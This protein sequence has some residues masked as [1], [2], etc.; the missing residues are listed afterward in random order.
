MLA[1]TEINVAAAFLDI[2][3]TKNVIEGLFSMFILTHCGSPGQ[4]MMGV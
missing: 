4:I 1:A 2:V 3:R